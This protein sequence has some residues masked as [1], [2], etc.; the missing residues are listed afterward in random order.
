[1]KTQHWMMTSLAALSMLAFG[2]V[3]CQNFENNSLT[4]P[5]IGA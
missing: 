2:L 5:D 4:T 3:G 1:M